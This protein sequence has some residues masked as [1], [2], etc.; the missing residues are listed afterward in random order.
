MGNIIIFVTFSIL[1]TQNYIVF[2]MSASGCPYTLKGFTGQSDVV[3]S[4]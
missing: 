2:K 4:A 3:L 1:N